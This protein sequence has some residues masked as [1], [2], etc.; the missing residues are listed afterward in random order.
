M[1]VLEMTACY[2]SLLFFS[3]NAFGKIYIVRTKDE[4]NAENKETRISLAGPDTV[5]ML[6]GDAEEAGAGIGQGINT[7]TEDDYRNPIPGKF[8]EQMWS[9]DQ[10]EDLGFG[11]SKNIEACKNHCRLKSRCTVVNFCPHI[12]QSLVFMCKLWACKNPIP[13]PKRKSKNKK[14]RGYIVQTIAKKDEEKSIIENINIKIE[15]KEVK[16]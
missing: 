16:N 8:F 10:C 1:I 15:Q 4:E 11:P 7:W 5:K 13:L 9:D 6:H 2:L 14:C 12:P 3:L